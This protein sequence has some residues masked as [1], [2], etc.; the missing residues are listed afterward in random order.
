LLF[1]GSDVQV[2]GLRDRD[3]GARSV[4]TGERLG[5]SWRGWPVPDAGELQANVSLANADKNAADG[6]K[7]PRTAGS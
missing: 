5:R 4:D 6:V 3:G 2:G 7:L 1:G